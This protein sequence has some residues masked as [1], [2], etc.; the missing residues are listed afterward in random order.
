VEEQK[1]LFSKFQ[2]VNTDSAGRPPGTGLGLYLSRQM[3][4]KLGGDV[5]LVESKP[6]LGSKFALSLPTVDSASAKVVTKQ[7]E[8]ESSTHTDKK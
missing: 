8:L 1:K 5:L 4:Q 3:A 6:E 2:Q 7:I